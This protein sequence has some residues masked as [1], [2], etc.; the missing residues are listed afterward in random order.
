MDHWVRNIETYFI[1]GSTV[2][3]AIW[4]VTPYSLVSE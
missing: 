2:H 3:V 4:V 1:K